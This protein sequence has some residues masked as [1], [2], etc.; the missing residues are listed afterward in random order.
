MI[1]I[2]LL[3]SYLIHQQY[4]LNHIQF[5]SKVKKACFSYVLGTCSLLFNFK[6][7]FTFN[8]LKLGLYYFK[9][10]NF[11]DNIILQIN[12]IFFVISLLYLLYFNIN[13]FVF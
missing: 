2:I 1:F 6:N 4:S 3:F 9:T 12:W 11:R 8:K 5:F 10:Y 7:L 13:Y